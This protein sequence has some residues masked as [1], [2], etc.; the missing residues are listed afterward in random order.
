MMNNLVIVTS[1]VAFVSVLSVSNPIAQAGPLHNSKTIITTMEEPL[2]AIRKKREIYPEIMD[3]QPGS[4]EKV[5]EDQ[6]Q[7]VC[8][9]GDLVYEADEAVPAEQPCLKCKC[10]P[11]GVHCETTRCEKK[12]GCR[13]IHKPNTCCPEYQ[14]ECEYEG[15]TYANG[16]RLEQKPGTE[17]KVCYCRGGEV[18]CAEVSCYIRNDCEGRQVPG[19]C[20]PKYDH[21]PPKEPSN[22]FFANEINET[23]KQT[24]KILENILPHNPD[25]HQEITIHEIIPEIKEIPITNSP[26]R[27]INEVVH[28]QLIKEDD[29]QHDESNDL[30]PDSESDGSEVAEVYQHPPSVLRIGDK[31]LFLKKDGELV[32]EK[33]VS[34]PATVITII[35]AEGLQRGGVEVEAEETLK[36]TLDDIPEVPEDEED[37]QTVAESTYILSLV[38]RPVSTTTTTTESALE[39]SSSVSSLGEEEGEDF[40]STDSSF[41]DLEL[42][43]GNFTDLS[44]TSDED[45]TTEG[46][47][48]NINTTTTDLENE[49]DEFN[50][51]SEATTISSPTVSPTPTPPTSS[52]STSPPHEKEEVLESN[53]EY[54]PIPD[55]MTQ[56]VE[57][58]EPQ[59]QPQPQPQSPQL[60]AKILP[61]VFELQAISAN[62]S[63]NATNSSWLKK[64]L[65][66][67]AATLP[68]SILTS[69]AES[70]ASTTEE[71]EATT[72]T[73]I[74]TEA[75]FATSTRSKETMESLEQN[76]DSGEN[77]TESPDHASILNDDESSNAS[78]E[79]EA[80]ADTPR[81]VSSE[82]EQNT[83]ELVE[84]LPGYENITA[85]PV[86][87]EIK[88]PDDV[89][90]V[91]VDLMRGHNS[92][93]DAKNATHEGKIEKTHK[94]LGK[95]ESNEDESIFEEL[96][97]EIGLDSGT[98]NEDPPVEQS[99]DEAKQIFKE[100]LDEA[101]SNTTPKPVNL[102]GTATPQ[103]REQHQQ[104]VALA[105]IGDALAKLQLRDSKKEGS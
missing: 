63:Q 17:C 66:N 28:K 26:K 2:N 73:T 68:E 32:N 35:G 52:I 39:Y 79:G 45:S 88:R 85:A 59:P 13:A 18:Q 40:N 41:D 10:Q 27:E 82:G 47:G 50:S 87:P 37:I 61:E 100:L 49:E 55:V 57:E 29:D 60:E 67:P 5:T 12:P 21:C 25:D 72:T 11:P 84:M 104:A 9:V 103:T 24:S 34:T 83:A 78:V 56:Q 102:Q 6:S 91:D 46:L 64:T 23:T 43:V 54:P 51:T 48:V 15:R 93:E 31:L 95:R 62:S 98:I 69:V 4:L 30:P 70:D 3:D 76:A 22:V 90:M 16:E 99:E 1:I 65:L 74:T 42:D 19:K 53:P 92:D 86:E 77:V 36:T 38:K 101:T 44:T 96:N 97:R 71:P 105:R 14:C 89:E 94:I 81:S 7:Q 20:C 75:T 8:V 80:T 33:G 58:P